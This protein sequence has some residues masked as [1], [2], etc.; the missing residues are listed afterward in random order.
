MTYRNMSRPYKNT[1]YIILYV[2]YIFL[3][4][5]GILQS[6]LLLGFLPPKCKNY[7][8]MLLPVVE[9][10]SR[11]GPGGDPIVVRHPTTGRDLKV[12]T[13]HAYNMNDVRG[14]PLA[15]CGGH[16]PRK[17]GSCN[18][19]DT[20]GQYHKST[21]VIPGA[22]RH[23]ERSDPL[24]AAYRREFKAWPALATLADLGKPRQRTKTQAIDAGN[25]VLTG[26]SGPK[27]EPYID[28]DIYTTLLWYHNKIKH[29]LYDA[30]HELANIIKQMFIWISNHVGEMLSN[31][32]LAYFF[33]HDAYCL[34][35]NYIIYVRCIPLLVVGDAVKFPHSTR[36][37]EMNVLGRFENLLPT[38][39]R[40][41]PQ[42]PW[43]CDQVRI[44]E[45][46]ALIDTG[47][48]KVPTG[49]PPVRKIEH[50]L[51]WKTSENLLFAGDAG[52]Y[53]LRLLKFDETY[54]EKFIE[55]LLLLKRYTA[56]CFCI[57][58]PKCIDTKVYGVV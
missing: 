20:G 52:A 1:T 5:I 58:C 16:P 57:S 48:L 17:I 4:G 6:V 2:T 47:R 51:F 9:Q 40:K 43:V 21:T 54:K 33:S 10:F 30:A 38:E 13:V 35:H 14:V 50:V 26:V 46:D 19:C 34:L 23:L 12:F 24:V 56:T 22:V 25:R 44:K 11:H 49:W 29:T 7:Q 18:R 15:T 28:V 8:N 27:E 42:P 32:M 45:L 53:L 39:E 55:L 37:Y 31:Y 3:Y 41:Y 36:Q